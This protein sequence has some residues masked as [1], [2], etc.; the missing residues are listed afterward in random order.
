MTLISNSGKA[1]QSLWKGVLQLVAAL[2]TAG[3]V[4]GVLAAT[5]LGRLHEPLQ[6][7]INQANAISERRFVVI[8]VPDVPELRQ[9]ASAMNSAVMRLK[10]MFAEE[11]QRLEALRV[12]ANYDALTGLPNRSPQAHRQFPGL[13]RQ[14]S[15]GGQSCGAETFW[16]PL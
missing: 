15:P 9:L 1:Y 8:D 12:A 4:G 7:V 13:R 5:I 10:S 14:R 16:P 2:A 6:R 11:A 3:L